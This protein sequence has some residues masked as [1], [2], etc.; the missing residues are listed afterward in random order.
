MTIPLVTLAM[1]GERLPVQDE[2]NIGMV[3]EN[4]KDPIGYLTLPIIHY[5][6]KEWECTS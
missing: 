6:S 4:G 1:L 2:D 5:H 3:M